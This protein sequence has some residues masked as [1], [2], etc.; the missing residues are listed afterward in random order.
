MFRKWGIGLGFVLLSQGAWADLNK[1][2]QAMK[3]L[4]DESVALNQQNEIAADRPVT[5]RDTVS[6]DIN[7]V[8]MIAQRANLNSVQYQRINGKALPFLV[9]VRNMSPSAVTLKPDDV[10]LLVGNQSYKPMNNRA[11][12]SLLKST[13]RKDYTLAE[14]IE[15]MK[16]AAG[17]GSSLVMGGGVIGL[18]KTVS[19]SAV[20]GGFEQS[21][22]GKLYAMIE[23]DIANEFRQGDEVLLHHDQVVVRSHS[24]T[25]FNVFFKEALLTDP[26]VQLQIPTAHGQTYQFEYLA[27]SVSV[28]D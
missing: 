2:Y 9:V 1:T 28:S 27:P 12:Q 19:S 10:R 3:L 5:L 18:A 24:M 7:G 20:S 15:R 25:S 13:N 22:L 23:S 17:V 6:L 26:H 11:M 4:A 21:D 16:I 14:G 8:Q